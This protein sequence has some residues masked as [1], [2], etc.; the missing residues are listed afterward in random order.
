MN[1]AAINEAISAYFEP[2]PNEPP[3]HGQHISPKS[4][5]WFRNGE[6]HHES[7]NNDYFRSEEANA[8]LL[9]AMHEVNLSREGAGE[10]DG[11][12]WRCDPYDDTKI[13]TSVYAPDRKTA[14][15]L[16]FCKFAGIEVQP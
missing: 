10:V 12:G 8:R 6:W 16:A 5:W 11:T 9:E 14:I 3:P 2:R 13:G 4:Y 1:H 15:V 7:V